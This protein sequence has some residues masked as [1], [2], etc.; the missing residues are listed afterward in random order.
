MLIKKKLD[1]FCTIVNY[2]TL[3]ELLGVLALFYTQDHI[4]EKCQI[5][6]I[7]K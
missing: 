2:D 6:G 3:K 1:P 4:L 5:F 7:S